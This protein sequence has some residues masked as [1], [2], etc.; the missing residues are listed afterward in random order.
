MTAQIPHY[1]NNDSSLLLCTHAEPTLFCTLSVKTFMRNSWG[2]IHQARSNSKTSP[3]LP[4]WLIGSATRLP[5]HTLQPCSGRLEEACCWEEWLSP[6]FP[7]THF[8]QLL[9]FWQEH[10]ATFQHI[11][12]CHLLWCLHLGEPASQH[13]GAGGIPLS[14]AV[15]LGWPNRESARLSDQTESD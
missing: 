9:P 2:C 10:M 4:M 13:L 3:W 12:L 5:T 7:L 11:Q 1:D 6:A 15:I 8:L 14:T